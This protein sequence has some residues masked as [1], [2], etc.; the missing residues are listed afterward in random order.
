MRN[1]VRN[2]LAAV[3]ALM[4]AACS[5]VEK[6]YIDEVVDL[7]LKT[8]SIPPTSWQQAPLRAN[9]NYLLYGARTNKE[10]SNRVG[11]YYYVRWYDAEPD[12]PVRLVMRYTQALTASRELTR[13]VELKEPRKEQSAQLT[14][15]F[16]AGEERR[17]CGDVLSWCVDL[18]VDGQLRDSRQSYL[19][20]DEK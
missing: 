4:L 5:S 12:K 13:T 2:V 15:F 7:P 9:A 17:R 14:K 3:G 19:W 10:K 16:F 11:D 6:S 8:T 20:E 18:Y 1:A